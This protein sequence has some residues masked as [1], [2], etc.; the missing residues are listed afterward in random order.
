MQYFLGTDSQGRDMLTLLIY[1]TPNTLKMGLIA[2]I[3]GVGLGLL[4]GLLA[5][6]SAASSTASSASWPTRS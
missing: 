4:F 5:G 6:N 2:G 1:G 3:I